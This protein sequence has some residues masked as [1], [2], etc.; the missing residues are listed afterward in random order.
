MKKFL[1]IVLTA[2]FMVVMI[3]LGAA[4]GL[5]IYSAMR[6]EAPWQK[7][8]SGVID[9]AD[10]GDSADNADGADTQGGESQKPEEMG[11]AARQEG[12][13]GSY[14]VKIKGA[15]A[16]EDY[17]GKQAAVVTYTWTNNGDSAVSAYAAI[18]VKAFQSGVQLDSA[19]VIDP[20][21]F[22]AA[23]YMR[24]VQPGR[25]AEVQSAFR[26]KSDTAAIEIEISELGG[27]SGNTVIMDY[28]LAEL[29]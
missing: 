12:D 4:A 26:L 3:L 8:D 6:G 2:L 5:T 7:A 27:S 22:D 1:G 24:E 23:N 20:G 11:S 10:T 15:A 9:S 18:Q 28:D 21:K 25:T 19:V 14:Y 13:L 17:E 16:A 29:E